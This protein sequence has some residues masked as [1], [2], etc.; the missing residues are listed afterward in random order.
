M[1]LGL[2]IALLLLCNAISVAAQTCLKIGVGRVGP[3]L[4]RVSG[5]FTAIRQPLIWLGAGLYAVGTVF[6]VRILTTTDL[7]YAYP[8]A[9][10][11]YAA[12]VLVSQW[13]LKEKVPPSRWAGL[14]IIAAG[15][16]CVALSAAT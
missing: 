14:A 15:I 11:S 2:T 8:F 5:L 9:A 3:A 4:H 16:C 12:G 13:L 7:S 6:W 1:S 10:I